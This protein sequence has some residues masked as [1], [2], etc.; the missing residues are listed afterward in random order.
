MQRGS[1]V[2]LSQLIHNQRGV[3]LLYLIIFFI[4]MGVL[5]SAGVRKFGSTV[6]LSKVTDTKAELERDVQMITAWAARNGKL[7]TTL[8]EVFG[9]APLDAWGREMVYVYDVNLSATSTGGLCGR[10]STATQYGAADVSFFLISGGDDST[11]DSRPATTRSLPYFGNYTSLSSKDLSRV[12]LLEE[13]KNKAGC[14]GS[15]VG[16]LRIL[17]NELPNAGK[18][19]IV[20]YR[21]TISGDGGVPRYSSYTSYTYT[22]SG[23]PIGL[24]SDNTRATIYGTTTTAC[25]KYPVNVTMTDSASNTVKKS[26]IL[27]LMSSSVSCN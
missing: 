22:I 11:V 16:S 25:R 19:S 2:P 23:L 21:A 1:I 10:R 12:V 18:R 27:N 24:K 15:T 26:Y 8:A 7:P 14:Y 13:L 9:S 3:A 6:T 5:V 20:E 4:L 17:N